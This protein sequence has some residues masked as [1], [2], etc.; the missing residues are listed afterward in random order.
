MT[1]TASRTPL[2]QQRLDT[3]PIDHDTSV[4][5]EPRNPLLTG[6][7][8]KLVKVDGRMRRLSY[9]AIEVEGDSGSTATT[10][11]RAEP[12]PIPPVTMVD[13]ASLQRAALVMRSKAMAPLVPSSSRVKDFLESAGV[14]GDPVRCGFCLGQHY[15][16]LS[17]VHVLEYLTEEGRNVALLAFVVFCQE[18]RD[19]DLEL[20]FRLFLQRLRYIPTEGQKQTRLIHAFAERYYFDC[21]STNLFANCE[22]VRVLAT[23]IF[24]LHTMLHN[25]Q[26][27]KNFQFEESMWIEHNNGR[28][29]G[30]YFD[31]GMLK[32]IY[33]TI[34]DYEILLQHTDTAS[35]FPRSVKHGWL[36]VHHSHS[37]SSRRAKRYWG[38]LSDGALV[39]LRV[40]GLS[41]STDRIV[42]L[43]HA[44]LLH[45]NADILSVVLSFQA[46][47]STKEILSLTFSSGW[48]FRTWLRALESCIGRPFPGVPVHDEPNA[49]RRAQLQSSL[50]VGAIAVPVRVEN[51]VFGMGSPYKRRNSLVEVVNPVFREVTKK[52]DTDTIIVSENPLFGCVSPLPSSKPSLHASV[53]SPDLRNSIVDR[54]HHRLRPL[55]D[56]RQ[57]DETVV[58]NPVFAPSPPPPLVRAYTVVANPVFGHVELEPLLLLPSSN[59]LMR[60][61]DAT[62]KDVP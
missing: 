48:A 12:E 9:S 56:N 47:T 50:S 41:K 32:D 24:M 40:P 5:E 28:N 34:R 36:Q 10:A 17:S 11:A 21:A 55:Y 1:V 60:S 37:T 59:L 33:C 38:E 4:T 13:V 58:V 53:S 31:E 15:D 3:S 14:L 25:V 49:N 30:E 42:E 62:N 29:G 46:S 39:L 43:D 61:N 7:R 26:V 27:A 23:G 22:A 20:A 52:N 51:P 54:V 18:F 44:Q 19:L 35:T 57:R 45:A 2:T 8:S 6:A 16:Q